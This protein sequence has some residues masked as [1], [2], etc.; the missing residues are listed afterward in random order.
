MK[1]NKLTSTLRLTL[2]LSV[3]FGLIVTSCVKVVKNSPDLNLCN[4]E[5]FCNGTTKSVTKIGCEDGQTGEIRCYCRTGIVGKTQVEVIKCLEGFTMEIPKS[6]VEQD[7][8]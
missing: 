1:K 7:T 4:Q 3:L 8:E 6:Q 2:M 5:M